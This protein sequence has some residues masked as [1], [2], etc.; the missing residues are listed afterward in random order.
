MTETGL[1]TPTDILEHLPRRYLDRTVIGKAG[2]LREGDEAV[3]DVRLTSVRLSHGRR[4][5][6]V[7]TARDA[8]GAIELLWFGGARWLS[9]KLEAGMRLLVSGTVTRFR[10]FQIV[11]PEFEILQDG[12]DAKGSVIPVYRLS[13]ALREAKIDHRALQQLALAALAV[14]PLEEILPACLRT[15][16]AMPRAQRLLRIHRPES[17]AQS[18]ALLLHEQAAQWFPT[19]ARLRRR[20]RDLV[21]RGRTFP[22]STRLRKAVEEALP[23][24]LHPTQR[25]AV[26]LLETRMASGD[27]AHMLLQG[28]VGSGKT[29]VCLLGA[30]AA[31]EAGAQVAV[32]APTEVLARQHLSTFRR[33]LSPLDI[34]VLYFASGVGREER[35]SA[36]SRL[37]HGRAAVAVGTHA[38]F[39]DD[40]VFRDLAMVVFDEQHRFGVGQ[41]QKLAAKGMHPHVVAASATPIPRSLLLGAHGD[42]EVLEVRGKPGNRLPIRTRVVVPDKTPDMMAWLKQELSNGAKLFWVVPRV[43]ESDEAASVEGSAERLRGILGDQH[44][45]ILHGRMDGPEQNAAI[46]ALREGTI[47]A[48]VSTTVVEVGVDVPDANLMVV[49]HPEYFGLAQ[50]HQLRGRVG[51]GGGQGWCF[52][53]P[54][55]EDK[56]ERLRRFAATED[57]FEIAEIDMEERGAGDLEGAVQSGGA[58]GRS[59]LLKEHIGL[60][61]RWREGMDKVLAGELPLT[62]EE[63]ARMDR[64]F[65]DSRLTE[66]LTG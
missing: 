59:G 7:A 15:G 19:L 25:E 41:R 57:G 63:Q 42:M 29:L 58:L 51:R 66:A 32:L 11:H 45:G 2:L 31:L 23:F 62:T 30:C 34:P 8:T 64:W 44:V 55:D 28:D 26:D 12:E 40:V 61:D 35:A 16:A 14:C 65:L 17:L 9:R 49:E 53:L 24:S 22:P 43:D 60:L 13:Q 48:L 52:L 46:D 6:L 39:T 20:K 37:A 36:L 10:G 27:Q 5:R 4:D 1:A 56:L 33:L 54:A 38:L 47:R 3:L 21:G 18:E 50:L